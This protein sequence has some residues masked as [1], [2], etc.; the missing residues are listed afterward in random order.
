MVELPYA[1][2]ICASP[3]AEAFVHREAVPVH[4]NLPLPT[5]EAARATVRGTLDLRVC[6]QCGFVGNAAFDQSRLAYGEQYDNTQTHSPAFNHYVDELVGHLVDKHGLR[7]G[8]VVEV[9]CG[10]GVFLHKLLDR[11]GPGLT[12]MGFDPSYVGPLEQRDGRLRFV[13]RYYD[14]D[15]ATVAAD[16]VLCRHV[17]EHV[18]NP[19]ELLHSVR[20]AVG[21][22]PKARIFFETPCMEWIARNQVTWDLFY[23][24]CSLFSADSLR[25]AFMLT[26]FTVE[27]VDHCFGG[28]YLWIE[29]RPA[30]QASTPHH[31]AESAVARIRAF[32]QADSA[33]LQAWKSDIAT[34]TRSGSCAL[35]G[36]GAKGVTFANLIDPDGSRIAHLVDINPNKQGKYIPGTGHEII[37][38]QDLATRQIT[39]VVVLNPNYLD[40]IRAAVHRSGAHISIY[41]LMAPEPRIP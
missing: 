37:G 7:Q 16:A 39:S 30:D 34:L 21:Y 38:P 17:I 1:C 8:Q 11:A 9:G 5:R 25:A 36:A 20:R 29:A 18:P 2:P 13:Q 27:R 28:Q 33:R 10:K 6:T 32:G 23:E 15:A 14:A 4:Q 31:S 40:E 41:D 24:H 12:A 19:L 3:N 35:W 26:G 22:R